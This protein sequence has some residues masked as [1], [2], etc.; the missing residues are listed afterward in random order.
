M[1]GG[2][3]CFK[4]FDI[5]CQSC[6]KSSLEASWIAFSLISCSVVI[7]P[8]FSFFTEND[9]VARSLSNACTSSN[10]G[11]QK[12]VSNSSITNSALIFLSDSSVFA[13]SK[14]YLNFCLFS[15]KLASVIEFWR[16]SYSSWSWYSYCNC[17][18]ML[19]ISSL[20][21]Y[22]NLHT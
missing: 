16:D 13:L 11:T 18:L 6:K 22:K 21:Y 5:V 10:K 14:K 12:T 8:Y 4:P 2:R 15:G 20:A 3:I 7:G 17:L 19:W 1:V 9:L